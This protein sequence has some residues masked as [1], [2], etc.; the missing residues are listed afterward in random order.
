MDSSMPPP[1]GGGE[2][3]PDAGLPLDAA[4]MPDAGSNI[5]QSCTVS[6]DSCAPT[7]VCTGDATGATNCVQPGFAQLNQACNPTSN[8]CAVGQ[9]TCVDLG[10]GAR[11]YVGCDGV[12]PCANS[13]DICWLIGEAWGVCDLYQLCDPLTPGCPSD[14]TCSI[15]QSD[16][17]CA[18]SPRGNVQ[19]NQPC[20]RPGMNCAPG[21]GLC[22]NVGDGPICYQVC[23]PNTTST[24]TTGTCTALTGITWGICY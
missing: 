3:I 4:G 15:A 5:G 19:L 16:G 21:Q 2:P 1:D 7:S 10:F 6:P 8:N 17:T 12:T 9:G 13:G 11:C 20:M 23:D 22:L 24:C 18:C 14:R